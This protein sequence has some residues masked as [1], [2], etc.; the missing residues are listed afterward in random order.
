[1][2]GDS[3]PHS[4]PP[5]PSLGAPYIQTQA[6]HHQYHNHQTDQVPSHLPRV[7]PRPGQ[8]GGDGEVEASVA[9]NLVLGSGDEKDPESLGA[10]GGDGLPGLPTQRLELG[11][12]LV[13]VAGLHLDEGLETVT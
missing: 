2:P 9:V 13:R 1:M 12:V 11:H 3:T 4:P 7:G 8:G 6:A 5:P 10:G